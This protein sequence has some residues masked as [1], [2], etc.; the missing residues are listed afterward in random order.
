[1]T[2][3]AD[4][5]IRN[6][7]GRYKRIEQPSLE[8][9]EYCIKMRFDKIIIIQHEKIEGVAVYLTLSDETYKELKDMNFDHADADS[10]FAENGKNIHFII[11]A[12]DNMHVILQG[13]KEVVRKEHPK[14][15][16]WFNPEHTKLY[17]RRF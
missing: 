3:L 16:S 8:A 7:Y 4:Y 1:M 15:I 17:K 6:Y 14:T 5:L 13:I 2:E 10:L 9:L 11:L 12:A